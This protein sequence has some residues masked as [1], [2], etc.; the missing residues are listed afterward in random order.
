MTVLLR[1]AKHT[2]ST[3]GS[4]E[5]DD[6]G[7]PQIGV[8]IDGTPAGVFCWQQQHTSNGFAYTL[9]LE[10]GGGDALDVLRDLDLSYADLD[11]A[12]DFQRLDRAA[13]ALGKANRS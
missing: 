1:T 11:A 7:D 12:P 4:L 6:N 10:P 3:I 8:A 9:S 2:L 5:L 13:L